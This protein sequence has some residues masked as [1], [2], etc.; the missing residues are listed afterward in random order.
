MPRS[1]GNVHYVLPKGKV[2]SKCNRRF[3]RYEYRV[4][5]SKEW[6]EN[7]IINRV[8]KK[9]LVPIVNNPSENDYKMFL[10]KIFYESMFH[11]RKTF[12]SNLNVEPLRLD[13][14]GVNK[15]V[16]EVIKDKGL[17]RGSPI[18][19]LFDRWR[20][21]RNKIELSYLLTRDQIFFGFRYDV[22]F[23]VL[24]IHRTRS[25]GI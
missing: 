13:L 24:A 5:N 21:K 18:P 10:L 9:D 25:G 12:F 19:R 7:R 14:I 4:L 20:L 16:Y 11:S 6:L 1:L 23:T 8:A 17:N 15:L 2:C 22:L 3:S